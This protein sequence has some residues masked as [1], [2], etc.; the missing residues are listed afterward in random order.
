MAAR[1]SIHARYSQ[2]GNNRLSDRVSSGG[3]TLH[4]LVN[5]PIIT[6]WVSRSV[7]FQIAEDRSPSYILFYISSP[8]G[9]VLLKLP[10]FRPKALIF[11]V[12]GVREL[13]RPVAFLLKVEVPIALDEACIQ[14]RTERRRSWLVPSG[15]E[16]ES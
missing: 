15:I 9:D 16:I 5:R 14:K 6:G 3:V 4:N 12:A 11:C 8:G 2:G 1:H 7:F 10:L 13:I